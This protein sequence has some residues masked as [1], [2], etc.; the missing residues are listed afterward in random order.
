MEQ[1][2]V[3][4]IG[5]GLA[6]LYTATR[7]EALHIPYV[8]LEA[9]SQLGG[10]ISCVPAADVD[11]EL[12]VLAVQI[13]VQCA[14]SHDMGPTW[15]FPHQQK[16]KA[17]AAELEVK[18]FEQYTAGDVLYQAPNSTKP[19]QITGAGA[20]QLFRV[21]GGMSQLTQKLHASI[22][23][24]RSKDKRDQANAQGKIKLEHCVSN[25]EKDE[26]NGLWT[27]S[28]HVAGNKQALKDSNLEHTSLGIQASENLSQVLHRFDYNAEHLVLALP[29]RIIQRDLA[30]NVWGSPLLNQRLGTVQT[31]MGAQAKFVATYPQPFW[32]DK[33]LSGQA[34]SQVGPMIEMHDASASENNSFGIFGFIGI[35][36]KQRNQ[37]SECQL[38]QACLDQ[39][40]FFYG[41]DAYSATDCYLKD[42][43]VDPFCATERDINE[44]S[45]HPDFNHRGL[46]DELKTLGLHLAGS[47][48]AEQDAGY[49]E[50]AIHAA[51]KAISEINEALSNTLN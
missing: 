50:G 36:A 37:L 40:A 24:K 27:V 47:E 13:A 38:K 15:I 32:R 12:G 4:I 22:D 20:M 42:W 26:E 29:P 6:G 14:N 19:R 1:T 45:K 10:R 8:L 28:G 2:K 3:I 5:G 23:S 39:L 16:I 18:L 34:F 51:D 9:K 41:E 46:D 21:D 49:L 17:L 48:F 35:P 43:A 11:R 33:G 30:S 44:P 7:L 31:W 25:I